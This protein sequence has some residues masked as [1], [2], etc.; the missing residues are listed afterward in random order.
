MKELREEFSYKVSYG[1]VGGIEDPYEFYMN[2]EDEEDF[3]QEVWMKDGVIHREGGPAVIVRKKED[4]AVHLEAWYQN[5]KLH[6]VDDP[7]ILRYD[8]WDSSFVWME[9]YFQNGLLHRADAAARI[10]WDRET[11]FPLVQSWYQ[12][13]KADRKNA[14]QYI[15][16]LYVVEYEMW[17]RDGKCHR[18]D[19]P[20]IIERNGKTGAVENQEWYLEDKQVVPVNSESPYRD[21]TP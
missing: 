16:G 18:E 9:G 7:A 6:R 21:P 2:L 14:P 17:C 20:A 12:H 10:E 1:P 4:G 15:R 3:Q 5:G 19:G 8:E 13:G 11:R